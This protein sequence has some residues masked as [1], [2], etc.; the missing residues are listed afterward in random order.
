MISHLSSVPGWVDT[1]V[2]TPG[3]AILLV[4]FV[5][6]A[7]IL[8]STL[9]HLSNWRQFR[10]GGLFDWKIMGSRPELAGGGALASA[11]SGVLS[12]HGY[13]AVLGIRLLA[14]LLLLTN[15]HVRALEAVGLT[16][17]LATTILI[18]LRSPLGQDGADQMATIIFTSL[19]I[20][21]F[22]VWDSR[23]THACIWFIALQSCLSYCVSGVAKAMGETWRRGEAVFRIFNTQTYG[24]PAAAGFLRDH[25]A[26][27]AWLTWSTVIIE[28]AFPLVLVLPLPVGC[29]FL[30]WGF[31]FHLMNAI[32]MG[33]NSFLWSFAATYPAIVYCALSWRS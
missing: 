3:S 16:I 2:R 22:A 14:I 18:N 32:V 12:F 17:I 13:L 5:A 30:A 31:A 1:S 8:V 33:L 7:G 6:L 27:N 21:L 20:N 15:P 29:L 10:A 25:R 19:W 4:R 28:T 9:E 26:M 11:L 24:Q 23:I